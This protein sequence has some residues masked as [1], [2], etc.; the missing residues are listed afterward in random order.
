VHG[1]RWTQA[2]SGAAGRANVGLCPASV[3]CICIMLFL[4]IPA[5]PIISKSIGPICTKF[6][7][8]IEH[9]DRT[10]AADDQSEISFP[11]LLP[12][13]TKMIFGDIR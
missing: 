2:A 8:L 11:V 6:S 7:R 10:M 12:L 13:G 1:C 3:I 5:R 4:T 9:R